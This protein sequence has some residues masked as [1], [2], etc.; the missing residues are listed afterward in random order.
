VST[1][2]YLIGIVVVAVFLILIYILLAG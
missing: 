1:R 2:H